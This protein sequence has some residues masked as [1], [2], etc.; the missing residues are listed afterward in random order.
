MVNAVRCAVEVQTEIANR[1]AGT[2]E[3]RRIAF[4]I[5][6]NIGMTLIVDG[7]DIF[8]DGVNIAARLQEVAAPGGICISSRVHEDVRDRLDTAFD[9]GGTQALKNI[10][11]PMQVWRWQTGAAV[12]AE[13]SAHADSTATARQ[14]LHRRPAIPEH[15]RRPRTR[16][17][18]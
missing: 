3:D 15:E 11:R 13:A 1:T 12:L 14:T 6:I 7:D 9:D 5:G 17:L 10:A 4:R 2:A 18:R 16:V 8:G